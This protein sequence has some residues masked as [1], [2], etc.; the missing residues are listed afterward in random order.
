M[1][2]KSSCGLL[3]DAV[4]YNKFGAF[5]I[6]S[7]T[8]AR[9]LI[10]QMG[11][12]A[13]LVSEKVLVNGREALTVEDVCSTNRV[14]L[15]PVVNYANPKPAPT[16]N[17]ETFIT[18][19]F[20]L[21]AFSVAAAGGLN[22]ALEFKWDGPTGDGLFVLG[23]DRISYPLPTSNTLITMTVQNWTGASSAVTKTV[24]IG[25][26]NTLYVNLVGA[27]TFQAGTAHVL[28]AYV[29]NV[30]SNAITYKWEF[31]NPTGVSTSS[32]GA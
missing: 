13:T 6:C 5:P 3:F 30:S 4:T 8:N 12:S 29:T 23:G 25:S 28:L 31:T 7:W 9:K 15:E 1:E 21:L 27:L 20:E 11:S 24:E 14:A 22:R 17:F 16:A 26:A 2:Q 18:D 32:L 10:V 19:G